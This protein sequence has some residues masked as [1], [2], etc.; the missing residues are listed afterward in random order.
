MKIDVK[1]GDITQTPS[2]AVITAINSGGMWFGGIDGAIKRVAGNIF[3]AQVAKALPLKHGS[4]VIAKAGGK[5]HQGR[6]SSVVFVI[7]DL[8]S[9]L[10]DVV[11]NGLT[12]AAKAGFKS[13]T[14]PTIRMGVMLGTVE[15]TP[16]QTIQEMVRGVK[17]FT[18]KGGTVNQIT[19]V[20]YND[21]VTQEILQQKLAEM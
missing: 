15:K 9:P 18:E 21:P 5:P 20:V 2:D 10:S 4:I 11:R 7:D 14:L 6:F 8:E 3:H 12:A 1:S 19:F 17:L 16:E 13:V